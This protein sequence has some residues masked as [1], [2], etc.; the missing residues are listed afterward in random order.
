MSR[1][2]NKKK[3]SVPAIENSI[4]ILQVLSRNKYKESTLTEVS[5]IT[6]LN[7]STCYRI[8][9]SL[10]RHA[11]VR[12][13]HKTKRYTLGP[14][15][16]VLGERAKEN[17]D[18]LSIISNYLEGI[19]AKTG[20]TSMLISRVGEDKTTIVS[21]VE[22]S[23]YGVKVSIGRHFSIIDGAYGMC[24]LAYMSPEDRSYYLKTGD[25]LKSF[26]TTEIASMDELFFDIQKKGYHITYGEFIKGLTGISAPI[27]NDLG[28]V[29][30][31][32]SLVGITA[33]FEKNEPDEIGKLIK[34]TAD[35]ISQKLKGIM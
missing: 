17:L 24:F 35:E 19:T 1:N 34:D 20:L 14:Y 31:V 9:N 28:E 4:A 3:Y 25:G 22:G 23:E 12:Y 27:I 10:E 16:L 30:M 11:M 32:I 7:L 13:D 29:E 21:K 8:M 6:S 5:E 15:I 33:Q 18:Y 2:Q 26:T